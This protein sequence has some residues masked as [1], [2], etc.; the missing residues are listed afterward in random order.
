M[1]V[2]NWM[3]E[4]PQIEIAFMTA[5]GLEQGKTKVKYRNVDMGV[6]EEVRL[7]NELDGVIATVKLDRQALPLLR[8]DTSFWVVTARVGADNISGLDTLLSGAY[9]QLAPGSGDAEKR[10]FVAL[11]QPPLTPADAP[12]LRLQLTSDR[13]SSVSTGD[14]V[15]FKGYKVG[16]VESMQFNPVDQLVH[17][18]IFIDAPYHE[19][20]NSSVRFWDVSGVS[21]A[22]DAS[23]FKVETGA[24]DTILFGGVTFSVPVGFKAGDEVEQNTEFKLHTSYDD[25]LANPF[26]HGTY[27]VVSFDQ[28]VKGLLPGAPVEFRGI[29]IGKVERIMLKE[30]LEIT[31]SLGEQGKGISIPILIYIEPGRMELPDSEDSIATMRE[32]VKIGVNNGLRATM[33]SGNLIT[34]AKYISI[35]FFAGAKAASLGSFMEY[36]TIP[37]IDSGLAQLDQKV[38]ALLDNVNALP[39]ADT[40]ASANNAIATLNKNLASLQLLLENQSTQQLPANLDQTLQELRNTVSGLSP[41]SKAY[42]SLN[43]SLLSLNRTINNLESLTRTLSDKP[44]AVLLPTSQVPDPI[45]EV[46]K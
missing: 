37:T 39:L 24:M 18:E 21:I 17:Y 36:T 27:Y 1:V 43:S 12:G 20:V 26:R 33:A 13:A 30:G 44:N 7:N 10:E 41:D 6:V 25:I 3:N 28:S 29:Q 35:D 4:G 9:I 45:P 42:Q 14:A 32:S 16:R 22:A 11:E 40:V 46:S 5:D 34:G 31:K 38:N 23:G 8:E 19:L 2:H 15:L